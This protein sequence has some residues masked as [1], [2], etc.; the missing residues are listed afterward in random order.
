MEKSSNPF[1]TLRCY[2]RHEIQTFFKGKE[3]IE[4]RD[5]GWKRFNHCFDINYSTIIDYHEYILFEDAEDTGTRCIKVVFQDYS[6]VYAAYSLESFDKWLQE[7]YLPLYNKLNNEED[8][9]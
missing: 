2:G 1:Y 7:N 3:K 6:S 4:L 9:S 8:Q 5:Q